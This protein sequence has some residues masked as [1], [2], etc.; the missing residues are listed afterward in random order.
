MELQV[1]EDMSHCACSS[2]LLRLKRYLFANRPL[3]KQ[4]HPH[5]RPEYRSMG[6]LSFAIQATSYVSNTFSPPVTVLGYL[7]VASALSEPVAVHGTARDLYLSI[8]TSG[9]TTGGERIEVDAAGVASV[10]ME[11]GNRCPLLS[12]PHA[13]LQGAFW[14]LFC[15]VP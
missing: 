5:Y 14:R 15:D 9:V 12:A 11:M 8:N 13:A 6:K 3:A 7:S 10:T 1:A 4:L 2:K